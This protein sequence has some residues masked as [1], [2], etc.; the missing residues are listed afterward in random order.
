MSGFA[1]THYVPEGGL[2]AWA[3]PDPSRPAVATIEHR[4]E[5]AVR[6][7]RGAWANVVCANAWAA[8]VDGRRL[9]PV[10]GAA[11]APAPREVPTT[12]ASAAFRFSAASVGAVVLAA[13]ALLPWGR[14]GL[15]NS[16]DVPLR[17]MVDIKSAAGGG[18]GVGLLL[19]AVALAGAVL[20]SLPGQA[21]WA[22]ACGWAGAALP[23]L[24]V[25][26]LQ[27]LIG[28]VPGEGPG[29]FRLLGLGVYITVAGGLALA[30]APA[31]KTPGR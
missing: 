10:G 4:V 24:F 23:L 18:P 6:E 12:R 17:F 29:L 28:Q 20:A 14:Q 7:W 22:K 1:P 30:L 27:R 9:V 16:F 15:G 25:I 5:V 2:Q 8:W 31:A 21:K 19:V 11:P 3:D 13:G 26:Q